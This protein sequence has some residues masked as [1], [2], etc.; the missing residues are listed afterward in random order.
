MQN[1]SCIFCKIIQGEAPSSVVFEDDKV[2]AFMDIQPV[3]PGHVLVVPKVHTEFMGE[4][5][6]DGTAHLFVVAKKINE[7]LRKSSMRCDGVNYLLADGEVA[8]QEVAHV[9]VHVIPRFANDGFGFTF[10]KT[11]LTVPERMTLEETAQNIRKAL[12]ISGV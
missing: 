9:H 7:A 11:Y 12:D 3:N 10:P 1:R 2:I 8:G 4:L 5:N 6:D